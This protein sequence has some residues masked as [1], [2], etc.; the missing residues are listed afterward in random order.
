MYNAVPVSA[1]QQSDP[2]IYIYVYIYILFLVS[3]PVIFLPKRLDI[4]PCA[5]D[6]IAR[7]F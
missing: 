1:G 2:V 5:G 4:V 3:D 6:L 7:P